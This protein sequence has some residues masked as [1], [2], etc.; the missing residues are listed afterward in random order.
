VAK[1]GETLVWWLLLIGL[2][3]STLSTVTGQELLVAAVAGLPCA[4]VATV[5][6]RVY[7]G[8]W[9]PARAWTLPLKI[10]RDCATLFSR[11][12]AVRRIP[13]RA[14]VKAVETVI[15]SVSPATVVLDDKDGSLLVHALG[16]EGRE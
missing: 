2:W 13:V 6:R 4:V 15:V 10:V 9:R 5:G 11:Q 1:A 3:I 16:R 12:A 14:D 8:R 7:G